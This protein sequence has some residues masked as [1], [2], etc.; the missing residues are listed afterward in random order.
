MKTGGICIS[1]YRGFVGFKNSHFAWSFRDRIFRFNRLMIFIIGR[2]V[3]IKIEDIETW[4]SRR[5]GRQGSYISR[6]RGVIV[7]KPKRFYFYWIGNKRLLKFCDL[8]IYSIGRKVGYK[9]EKTAR[10][11]ECLL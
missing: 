10:K 6:R 7:F 8:I 2:R 11:G 5:D 9:I 3:R 4:N 1:R